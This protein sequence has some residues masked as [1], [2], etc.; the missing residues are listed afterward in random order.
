MK[1]KYLMLGMLF[2]AVVVSAETLKIEDVVVTAS[3]I[4]E[5]EA[6]VLAPVEVVTRDQIE[7]MEL[8]TVKEVLDLLPGVDTVSYGGRGQ[9]A[10]FY[11]RGGKAEHVLVLLDGNPLNSS[12]IAAVN[13]NFLPADII[14]GCTLAL[15]VCRHHIRAG[16]NHITAGCNSL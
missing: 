3:R 11:V 9:S 1:V 7:K 16:H 2:P 5:S 13:P 8:H 12:G 6:S 4:P 15:A 14:D 10:N